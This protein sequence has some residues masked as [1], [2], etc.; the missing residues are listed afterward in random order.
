MT[1][2]PQRNTIGIFLETGGQQKLIVEREE[3]SEE[4]N[5]VAGSLYR[6]LEQKL[7]RLRLPKENWVN[8]VSD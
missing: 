8:S 6:T 7:D 5:A 3:L 1:Y 4:E 2:N